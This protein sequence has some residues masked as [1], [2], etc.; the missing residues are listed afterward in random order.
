MNKSELVAAMA[1]Q[2]GFS[3]D[4]ETMLKALQIL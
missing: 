2:T 1:E 3:K 4:S